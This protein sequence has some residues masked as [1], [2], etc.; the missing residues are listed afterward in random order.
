MKTQN[1]AL[2]DFFFELGMMKKIEHCGT[3]FAGVKN[4]DTIGEHT[5]R[6]SQIGYAIAV[7]EGGNPE[8]VAAMCAMHDIGEIRIGDAHRIAQRYLNV[9]PAEKKAFDEQTEELP[10]A[11]RDRLRSLW[12]EFNDLKTLDAKIARDADLLETILQAKE[13]LDNGY[14]AAERWLS[15]GSTYLQTKTAKELFKQIR[16]TSFAAWW[17]NLNKV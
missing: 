13:Y 6:A 14:K 4:P 3:K 8:K 11:L 10:Q 17:D 2:T 5:C 12:Q 16:K 9:P 15:N 1:K 7:Q